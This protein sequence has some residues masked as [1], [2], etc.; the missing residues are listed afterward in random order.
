MKRFERPNHEKV[1]KEEKSELEKEFAEKQESKPAEPTID[2]VVNEAL[3]EDE[4]HEVEQTE[5]L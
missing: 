4:A 2:D 1:E 3:K 5:L